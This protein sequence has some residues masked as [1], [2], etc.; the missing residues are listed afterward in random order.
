MAG[1][2]KNSSAAADKKDSVEELKK[3]FEI[4]HEKIAKIKNNR[5]DKND[6][7]KEEQSDLRREY[8]RMAQIAKTLST[9]LTD[10]A[11]AK[12]FADFVPQL[13]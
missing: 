5:K 7:S 8:L 2:G 10:E 6:I 12:K 13:T 11:E 9:R 1:I 3:Q 4:S